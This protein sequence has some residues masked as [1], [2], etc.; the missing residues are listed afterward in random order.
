VVISSALGLNYI[1][2]LTPNISPEY[3][4]PA[5]KPTFESWSSYAR[6]VGQ[7]DVHIALRRRSRFRKVLGL[8]QG[9]QIDANDL[10]YGSRMV[11]LGTRGGEKWVIARR[12]SFALEKPRLRVKEGICLEPHGF[13]PLDRFGIF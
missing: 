6:I 7:P 12:L 4:V 8:V 13:I 3:S 2:N 1:L 5:E 11:N 10:L 9:Q